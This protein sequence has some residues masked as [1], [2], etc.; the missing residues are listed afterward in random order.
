MCRSVD[1]CKRNE[2]LNLQ[3]LEFLSFFT[4]LLIYAY[5]KSRA[6]EVYAFYKNGDILSRENG[7]RK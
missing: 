2:S 4:R 5:W 7:E 1:A 3:I 6:I